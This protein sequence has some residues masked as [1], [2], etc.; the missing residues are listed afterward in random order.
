VIAKSFNCNS[1]SYTFC[2]W[3]KDPKSEW[4]K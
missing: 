1:G 2:E 3:I 4:V